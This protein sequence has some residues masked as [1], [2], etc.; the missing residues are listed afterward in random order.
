MQ[1]IN[2][3]GNSINKYVSPYNKLWLGSKKPYCR[4]RRHKKKTENRKEMK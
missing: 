2:L 4:I 1:N 3:E